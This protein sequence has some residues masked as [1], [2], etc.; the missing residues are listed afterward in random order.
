MYIRTA[1]FKVWLGNLT[2][3]H[4]NHDCNT[5]IFHERCDKSS[6]KIIYNTGIF[7]IVTHIAIYRSL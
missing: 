6:S 5:P 1:L 2:V 4:S 3:E 7:I